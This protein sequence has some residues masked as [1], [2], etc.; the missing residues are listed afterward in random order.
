MIFLR[1]ESS[2]HDQSCSTVRTWI[3]ADRVVRDSIP[4]GQQILFA[5]NPHAFRFLL[6]GLGNGD[7][8]PSEG[9]SDPFQRDG[10]PSLEKRETVGKTPG[11]GCED[12]GSAGDASREPLE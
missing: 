2:H 1:N 5:A 4:D 6:I 9:R 12:N 10:N 7:D 8:F 3:C 11:M